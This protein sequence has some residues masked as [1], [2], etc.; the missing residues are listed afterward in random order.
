MAAFFLSCGSSPNTEFSYSSV[1]P[2]PPALLGKAADKCVH[3]VSTAAL[4][5]SLEADQW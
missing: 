5:L 4:L 1:F 3:V 2:K